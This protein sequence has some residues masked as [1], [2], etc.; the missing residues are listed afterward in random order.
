MIEKTW[1]ILF[2]MCAFLFCSGCQN[3]PDTNLEGSW[4]MNA[5]TCS[6]EEENLFG[7]N[8]SS[9]PCD[10]TGPN[11]YYYK[12]SFTQDTYE[13]LQVDGQ[14]AEITETGSY[15]IDG[16]KIEF[17]D[18]QGLSINQIWNSTLRNGPSMM[19][20]GFA[21]IRQCQSQA[22]FDLL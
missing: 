9:I 11:C 6:G 21:D 17:Y 1:P 18:T 12:L 13:I 14:G 20:F 22:T 10:G 15:I 3:E 8:I 16:V 19:L 4:V 2:V 7:P 5:W